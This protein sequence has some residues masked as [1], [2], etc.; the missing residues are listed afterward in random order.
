MRKF[1]IIGLTIQTRKQ[2][3]DVIAQWAKYLNSLLPAKSLV[4][5]GMG[6]NT[7][8]WFVVNK[9]F[10]DNTGEEILARQPD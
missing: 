7:I 1:N 2:F 6:N 9:W 3:L 8:I 5:H 4:R 10:T